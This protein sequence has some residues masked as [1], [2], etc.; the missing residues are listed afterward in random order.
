[1][2]TFYLIFGAVTLAVLWLGFGSSMPG[3]VQGSGE[4]ADPQAHKKV[5]STA[6]KGLVMKDKVQKTKAEWKREL[7]PEQYEITREKGTERAFTGKYWD[8]HEKGVYRC[9]ACGNEL[10]KS[11]TKF[12]SGSGWPSFWAPITK[13]NVRTA[14]D[15]SLFMQR[16]EVLCSLCDAHLGH[17][18]DDGPKPTGLR[19]CVNSAALDFTRQK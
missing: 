4:P 5:Y 8:H 13:E 12:D 3:I 7:T 1:M 6:A 11:D 2:K 15:D 19:Y 9:V 18:F 17:V 10:F 16:T 14:D